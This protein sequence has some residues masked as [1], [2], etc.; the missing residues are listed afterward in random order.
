MNEKEKKIILDSIHF[1]SNESIFFA[2]ELEYVKAQTYDVEYPELQAKALFPASTEAPA[3]AKV[4]TYRQFDKLGMAKII[5]NYADD[6]PRVNLKGKEF[7]S[8]VRT[9]GDAYG[10]SVIDI[11]HAAMVGMPLDSKLAT[12]AREAVEMKEDDIA[13]FGDEEFGLQGILTNGNVSAYVVPDGTA[14]VTNWIPNSAG[15]GKTPLEIVR[16]VNDVLRFAPSLTRGIERPDTL[17]ISSDEFTHIST[18]PMSADNTNTTIL[19]FLRRAHPTVT[20]VSVEKLS[21]LSPAR[22]GG[23]DTTNVM[24]A[25]RRSPDRLTFEI[26][27][28]FTQLPVQERNLEY[29]VNCI[30][31]NGGIIIYRPLSVTIAEGI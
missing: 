30:A 9:I 17:A 4:I 10:Y 29:V 26:P 5:A 31:R 13:F 22:V 28:M 14:S 20:F 8:P 16:D 7:S 11:Q 18:T 21:D 23:G 1:D 3:G 6:L 27:M 15:S 24:V 25:Y 12:T 19:E 2:R